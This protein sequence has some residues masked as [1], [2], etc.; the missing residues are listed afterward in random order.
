MTLPAIDP[1]SH[2]ARLQR[3]MGAA[4]LDGLVVHKA[5]NI[6]HLLGAGYPTQVGEARR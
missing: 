6:V 3:A 2:A 4:G 5:Q 1:G